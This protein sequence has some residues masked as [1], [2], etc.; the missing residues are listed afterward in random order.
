MY[1]KINRVII[2]CSATREG[3]HVSIDTIRNWHVKGNGWSDIGYHYVIDL[4]G[5]IHTGRREDMIGA[6]VRG[7][8]DDSIGI[9]YVGG[10]DCEGNPK[11]TRTQEQKDALIDLL[12]VLKRKYWSVKIQGHNEYSDKACPCFNASKEYD[13]I[14]K[15]NF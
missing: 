3:Q 5:N 14:T 4:D 2:H 12:K 10:L 8:N 1:R 15:Y 6:H 13:Y 7:H 9:C 11:D